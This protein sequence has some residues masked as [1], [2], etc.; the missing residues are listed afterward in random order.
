MSDIEETQPK[1]TQPVRVKKTPQNTDKK[2]RRPIHWS[3][4]LVFILLV[5]LGIAA[6]YG[7]GISQRLT[8]QKTKV[9][10]QLD[11]QYQLGLQA[12]AAGDYESARLHF[13]FVINT[14]P[15]YPGVMGAYTELQLRLK[16]SPTPTFTPTPTITPTPDLR[17]AQ[18]IYNRITQLM[19]ANPQSILDWDTVISNLDSLRKA[20]PTFHT[21][22]IDGMYYIALRQRGVG[23]IMAPTCS[24]VNMEGGIYDLTLAE[25]FG[26]LDSVAVSL[27]TF[28][29]LFINGSSYWE[30]NWKQAQ[31]FFAQA[32]SLYPDLKDASCQSAA[33]R[34]RYATIQ[35]AMILANAG[36][37][38]GAQEQF[39]AAYTI[40]SDEN[41]LSFNLATQ[42][43]TT[44]HPATATSVASPTSTETPTPTT[45]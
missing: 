20:A 9:A 14:N 42:L 22:E 26:P 34:W 19:T 35:Y 38:C 30:Q 21:A 7:S 25:R 44:C 40:P 5:L 29:R 12:L 28:S 16:T 17:S 31:Y 24:D 15:N 43:Y 6:G 11:S 37:A 13:E 45:P 41:S 36:D 23:K 39:D 27:R 33:E 18:E 2:P 32:M 3:G 4:I 1:Q 10:G 8:A